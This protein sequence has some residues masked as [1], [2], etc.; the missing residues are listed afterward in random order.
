[1]DEE[2]LTLP[3]QE[4]ETDSKNVFGEKR[5][6]SDETKKNLEEEKKFEF[7]EIEGREAAKEEEE[8]EKIGQKVI[9]IVVGIV[10]VG[11]L[12]GLYFWLLG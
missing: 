7:N 9:K 4:N 5:E 11:L 12:V 6:M 3:E 1:M 10:V 2:D 8:K